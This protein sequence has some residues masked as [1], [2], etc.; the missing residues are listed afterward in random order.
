MKINI[1]EEEK[2]NILKMHKSLISEQS[3]VSKVGATNSGG[4]NKKYCTNM[5]KQMEDEYHYPTEKDM[6]VKNL[7]IVTPPDP[8]NSQFG[9]ITFDRGYETITLTC[10]PKNVQSAKRYTNNKEQP[11]K[12]NWYNDGIY[13]QYCSRINTCHGFVA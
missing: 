5:E 3:Q 10:G 2:R 7:K 8:T 13:A 6:K 4:A 9:V 12:A 1:T 11:W